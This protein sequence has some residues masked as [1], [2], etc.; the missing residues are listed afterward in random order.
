MKIQLLHI[1][2]FYKESK[3]GTNV[4]TPGFCPL[5]RVLSPWS[6]VIAAKCWIL[7][8]RGSLC[9]IPSRDALVN[10]VIPSIDSGTVG[11]E[12]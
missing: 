10:L 2:T 1:E 7:R 5:S 6:L 12:K 3:V 9:S 4:L 8:A 11:P